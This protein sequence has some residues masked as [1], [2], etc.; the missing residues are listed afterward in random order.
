M[1]RP[2]FDKTPPFPIPML[3]ILRWRRLGQSPRRLQ[4]R[5][6]PQQL[7][8]LD[9]HHHRHA[10]H[11]GPPLV[12]LLQQHH[13][14][15]DPV[16]CGREEE[17]PRRRPEARRQEAP[18]RRGPLRVRRRRRLGAQHGRGRA[19]RPRERRP[20]RWLGRGREG[21]RHGQCA[22]ELCAKGLK[23][24]PGGRVVFVCV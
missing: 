18:L 22:G 2:P 10:H 3:T 11:P 13:L 9:T 12:H 8:R 20:R 24:K 1:V 15:R 6:R 23:W 7:R 14:V 17:G 16:L 5:P 19:L 21:G 4:R